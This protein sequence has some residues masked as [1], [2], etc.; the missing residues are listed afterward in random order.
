MKIENVD[1]RSHIFE[2]LSSETR[3][4]QKQAIKAAKDLR[5]DSKV[6]RKLER[7]KTVGE[8]SRIMITAR[9]SECDDT[10]SSK[11]DRCYR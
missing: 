11:T 7:A 1:M 2:E 6:V 8:I 10:S 3:E 9:K 5:Y 4:Y